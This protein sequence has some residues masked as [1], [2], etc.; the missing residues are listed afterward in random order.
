MREVNRVALDITS[1]PPGHHRVG[2]TAGAVR[3][4]NRTLSGVVG[5]LSRG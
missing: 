2:V 4:R 3:P 1:K 5:L